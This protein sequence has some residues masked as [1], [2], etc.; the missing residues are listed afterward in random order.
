MGRTE[1][2]LEI[3]F[4]IIKTLH[5]HWRIGYDSG[6]TIFQRGNIL[7]HYRLDSRKRQ[8]PTRGYIRL[9]SLVVAY[10]ML[11]CTLK[12]SEHDPKVLRV[13]LILTK[14][15]VDKIL[16]ETISLFYEVK[17]YKKDLPHK[18]GSKRL[19]SHFSW[20]KQ[21]TKIT[22]PLFLLVIW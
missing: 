22:K 21:V 17:A 1:F 13:I 19:M 9:T 16:G 10:W 14:W 20:G 15:N 18:P 8:P 2:V 5:R 4:Y 3:H 11:D 6:V 12:K 7:T